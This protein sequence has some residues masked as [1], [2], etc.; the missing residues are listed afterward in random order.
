MTQRDESSS[1]TGKTCADCEHHRGGE[2]VGP[3]RCDFGFN[4]CHRQLYCAATIDEPR[5]ARQC[6]AF[7][8]GEQVIDAPR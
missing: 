6:A 4:L 7:R 2:E 5:D 1:P 3:C 8:L